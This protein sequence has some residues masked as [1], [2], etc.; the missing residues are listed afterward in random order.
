MTR[1]RLWYFL[2]SALA[3]FS[4]DSSP[5]V[6]S[7]T[8]ASRSCHGSLTAPAKTSFTS[9][10]TESD[11]FS[12]RLL[13]RSRS[14]LPLLEH[15]R[16]GDVEYPQ[17]EGDD[18]KEEDERPALVQDRAAGPRVCGRGIRPGEKIAPVI[19][20][21]PRDELGPALP[22]HDEALDGAPFLVPGIAE[23]PALDRH[24]DAGSLRDLREEKRDEAGKVL[25]G[26]IGGLGSPGILRHGSGAVVVDDLRAKRSCRGR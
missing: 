1:G 24:L 10:V 14:R 22:L 11:T 25:Q 23:D 7:D 16:P 12:H 8:W 9:S 26:G 6:L 5:D 20:P 15:P 2:R 17:G 18:D 13:V 4:T 19:L 21:S 3:F